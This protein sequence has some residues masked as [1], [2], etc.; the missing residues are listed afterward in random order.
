MLR[1]LGEPFVDLA[2]GII[3]T[4]SFFFKEIW[5]AIRQPRLI[6]SVLLGPFLRTEEERRSLCRMHGREPDA[7]GIEGLLTWCDPRGTLRAAWAKC[8]QS[9]TRCREL[10]DRNGALVAARM[11]RVDNLLSVLT[12][13]QQDASTYG[14]KGSTSAIRSGRVLSTEA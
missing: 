4:S 7:Q 1:A 14:P 6:L 9:A 8:A 13:Q 12:G 3:R 11:K 2:K 10:N 5:S